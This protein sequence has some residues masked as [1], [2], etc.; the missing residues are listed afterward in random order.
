MSCHRQGFRNLFN[1]HAL[2]EKGLG[3]VMIVLILSFIFLAVAASDEGA[4]KPEVK[5]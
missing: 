1:G 4:G 2:G 3:A 5:P